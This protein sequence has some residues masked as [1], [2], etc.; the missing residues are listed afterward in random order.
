M[1]YGVGK[2]E[3]VRRRKY[4]AQRRSSGRVESHVGG[5]V[6]WRRDQSIT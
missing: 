6:S 3:A 4:A 1:R 2:G 5:K